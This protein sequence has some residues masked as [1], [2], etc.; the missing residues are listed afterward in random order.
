MIKSPW[1]Q[2]SSG[3]RRRP[4]SSRCRW[5]GNVPCP[6]RRGTRC[7][8]GPL[9]YMSKTSLV[10]L[11]GTVWSSVPEVSSSGPRSARWVSTL[12]GECGKK[13]AAGVLEQRQAGAGDGPG[14]VQGV[15]LLLGQGVAEGVVE[16]LGGQRH[17]AVQVGGVAQH[18]ERRLQLRE[19][20]CLDALDRRRGRSRPRRPPRRWPAAPG[21]SDRRTSVR[22]RRA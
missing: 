12:A 19:R 13:F 6:R 4:L 3:R 20:Q 8:L 22:R 15:G 16:L 10:T 2:A 14:V 11:S 7:R 1:R 17:R 9:E 5:S 18:R 21:R